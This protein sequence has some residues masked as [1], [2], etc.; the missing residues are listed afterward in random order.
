MKFPKPEPI[1]LPPQKERDE[2]ATRL[3]VAMVPRLPIVT[4]PAPAGPLPTPPRLGLP[5]ADSPSKGLTPEL[6]LLL[7]KDAL[8]LA[9]AYLSLRVQRIC[10]NCSKAFDRSLP[11]CPGCGRAPKEGT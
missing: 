3:L 8:L 4:A 7:A 5:A 2:L 10:T 11:H 6:A 9:D 1:P